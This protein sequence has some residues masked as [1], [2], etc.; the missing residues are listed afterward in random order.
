[1]SHQKQH[2]RPQLTIST[3]KYKATPP[4][5]SS[6]YCAGPAVHDAVS[7]LISLVFSLPHPALLLS[8]AQCGPAPPG[9]TPDSWR[10]GRDA[11][12]CT[13]SEPAAAAA[14]V[15]CRCHPAGLPVSARECWYMRGPPTLTASILF[16]IDL[17]VLIQPTLPTVFELSLTDPLAHLHISPIASSPKEWAW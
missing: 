16:L 1:M 6:E 12:Q 10:A 7:S 13:V 15:C 8:P 2:T 14:A 4:P 17:S 11:A 3:S 9:Q 5:L